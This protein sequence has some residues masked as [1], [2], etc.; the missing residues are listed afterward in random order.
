MP[1]PLSS[2]VLGSIQLE[3]NMRNW[4]AERI[5]NLGDWILDLGTSLRKFEE[6]WDFC[7]ANPDCLCDDPFCIEARNSL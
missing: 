2:M 6:Y 3:V 4:I 1:Q 5:I 7:D